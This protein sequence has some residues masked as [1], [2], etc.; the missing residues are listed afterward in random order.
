M[1]VFAIWLPFGFNLIGLIEEWSILGLFTN[2]GLFFIVDT[3]GPLA[4]HALRPLTVFPQ[5]VAYFLDPNSF[6]YWHVLLIM[7]LVTKS[8]ASSTL[9]WQATGSLRWS[10]VMGLMVIIYPADT[11]Q[12]ALRAIHINCALALLLLACTLFITAFQTSK[13]L[14]TYTLGCV[15]GFCLWAALNMYEA[16]L[17]L[18]ILPFLIMYVRNGFHAS[19]KRWWARKGLIIIWLLSIGIYLVYVAVISKTITSYQLDIINNKNFLEVFL[20]SYPKLFNPGML[21]SLIG[22]WFDAIRILCKELSVIGYVYILSAISFVGVIL[23]YLLNKNNQALINQNES[24]SKGLLIRLTVIA[25]LIALLGYLP[26]IFSTSHVLISQ[27]TYLFATPGAAMFW[28][29]LLMCLAQWQK[30]TA[31]I[32]TFLFFAIGLGAQIFQFHHYVQLAETQRSLLRNIVTNFD[33]APNNKTLI[34]LDESNQLT[35]T[36]MLLWDNLKYALTY[37]YGHSINKIEVCQMPD[38]AWKLREE[39]LGRSGLCIEKENQWVFQAPATISGPGYTS[40]P[41]NL[42][43]KQF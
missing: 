23:T 19:L 9:F 24:N 4:G 29:A 8:L 12:L 31:L 26:F 21:R 38:K 22:G 20:L 27:R 3:T 14:A 25:L 32:V 5:A 33:G 6:N 2:H 42:Q 7:A 15:A 37:F 30:I 41:P 1:I 18:V 35:Y 43:I 36:W 13:R 39:T 34:I 10:I 16:A 17:P 28:V 40:P 11:M